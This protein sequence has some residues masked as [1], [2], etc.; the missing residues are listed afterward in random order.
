MV[1]VATTLLVEMLLLT[2]TKFDVIMFEL[3][4]VFTKM[5]HVDTLDEV[6]FDVEI[7]DTLI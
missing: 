2:I 1:S 6:M 5:L 3:I 4:I 7:F